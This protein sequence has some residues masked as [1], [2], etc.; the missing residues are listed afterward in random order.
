MDIFF[1]WFIVIILSFSN[2]L[3]IIYLFRG[4]DWDEWLGPLFI[5]IIA[6]AIQ[7]GF[8]GYIGYYDKEVCVIDPIE[9]KM[10]YDDEEVIIKYEEKRWEI[11]EHK[12]YTQLVNKCFYL[13]KKED[14]N[15][16]GF[17]TGYSYTLET[18]DKKDKK[19]DNAIHIEL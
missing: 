13:L 1:Y 7:Y 3:A 8:I 14:F 10:M 2:I 12:K 15:V 11:K 5:I 9:V 17:S 16:F 18:Y 19:S 6:G 4:D